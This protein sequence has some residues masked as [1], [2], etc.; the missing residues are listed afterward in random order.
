MASIFGVSNSNNRNSN[1][2][3]KTSFEINDLALKVNQNDIEQVEDILLN[4]YDN[5]ILTTNNIFTNFIEG[6]I[7]EDLYSIENV[8]LLIKRI[9]SQSNL[10]VNGLERILD[11]LRKSLTV[12][13]KAFN[14]LKENEQLKKDL[15]E[16]NEQLDILNDLEK[17]QDY[18]NELNN[19]IR[20]RV[21]LFKEQ[22]AKMN[23]NPSI[24]QEYVLYIQKYGL[25]PDGIF[26]AEKLA[27][28]L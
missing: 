24:K 9:N 14:I 12:I 17:L 25:P 20:K 7:D 28:F 22:Q 27:E 26:D 5:I 6:P 2:F 10:N 3:G 19:S 4:L 16:K 23:I 8:T 18:I 1:I 13:Q 21:Y 11:N 15:E